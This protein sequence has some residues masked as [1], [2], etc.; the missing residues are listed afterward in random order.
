MANVE[1]A[2]G[3]SILLEGA[4]VSAGVVDALNKYNQ[5]PSLENENAF[6]LAF[7]KF[8]FYGAL[9]SSLLIAGAP[10]S[11]IGLALVFGSVGFEELIRVLQQHK[12]DPLILDLDGDGVELISLADSNAHLDYGGDGFAERTGWV[13]ADDGILV[14]DRNANGT[15]DGIGEMFGSATQDGFEVLETLDTNAD[16][17]IDAADA[18]FASLRV[19]Q[20]ANEDGISDAGELKTLA[21]LGIASVSVNRTDVTGTNEG[22]DR[23][24]AATFSKTDGSTGAAETIYFQT[25]RAD[26]VDPTPGFTPADGVD[27]LPQLPG[28]G[29]IFSIAYT[30]TNDASFRADWTALADNAA[31]MSEDEIRS[32]F[33]ELLLRWAGV[34]EVDRASRGEFVDARHLALISFGIMCSSHVSAIIFSSRSSAR[35]SR[36]R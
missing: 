19:W 11:A 33:S 36:S 29:N 5:N 2:A 3:L 1:G 32:A 13:K 23:G 31:G 17:K 27:K 10:A 28:S 7:S 8:I 4:A 14:F 18:D 6:V 34:D 22:H 25:D 15:V 20:D 16:G 9:I 21:E 35:A 24:F 12:V 26:T 30:L